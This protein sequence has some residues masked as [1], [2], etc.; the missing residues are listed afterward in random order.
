LLEDEQV[1]QF[2]GTLK[3]HKP[4]LDLAHPVTYGPLDFYDF[5][6]EHKR[7]QVEAMR[8]AGPVILQVAE[9]F[10]KL[11]GRHYGYFEPYK[12]DDADV[13]V[14]V[15]NSTAGTARSVADRLRQEGIKAGVLKLRVFRPFPAQ[16]LVEALGHCQVVGVMDR[17]ISFGAMGGPVFLET[18]A[19]LYTGN[20]HVPLKNFIYGLGGRDVNPDQVETAFRDLVQIGQ[21]GQIG[22]LVTYLGVR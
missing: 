5:Y 21:T 17:S 20:K 6:F 13:A 2:V 4:L 11:S 16:E 14:V 18:G 12:L 3:P 8:H 9:E 10:A 7:Q 1:R 19:A 22:E 15:L